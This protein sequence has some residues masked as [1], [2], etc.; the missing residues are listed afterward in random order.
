MTTLQSIIEGVLSR[1]C[2]LRVTKLS[3]NT[4]P[5]PRYAPTNNVVV[6]TEKKARK[7]LKEKLY[8]M[9][10]GGLMCCTAPEFDPDTYKGLKKNCGR[11]NNHAV[12]TTR[13]KKK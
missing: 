9:T 7:P 11:P 5:Q 12:K 4:D 6:K 10:T 13:S 1:P 8:I 2:I 3:K